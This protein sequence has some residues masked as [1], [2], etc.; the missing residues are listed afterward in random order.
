MS[1]RVGPGRLTLYAFLVLG[2]VFAVA[3]IAIVVVNSFNSSSFGAWPPPGF[4]T[5]WYTNLFDNGGFGGPAVRSIE[6]A[7]V[8]TAGSLLIGTLAALAFA[9]Y[10]L[11]GRRTLQGYLAAPLIVPKVAIGIAAFILFLKL[12]WYGSFGSL[13]LAHMLI[14]L[15]FVVT[16]ALAGLARVDR[17]VEEAAMDLGAAPWQVVWRATLPQMRGAL[18]A[19][20]AFSI[21]ISFD[22]LDASVFLV[23]LRSNTLPTAMYIYMQK[24]QD[25]TLAAL[26]T[27]LIGASLLAALLIAVLIGRIGGMRALS[28]AREGGTAV[29]LEDA[30]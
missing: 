20:A 16:L 4:S 30:V 28:A 12:G 17:T 3:P 25:P 21:I 8:A 9:R 14:T 27:I 6:L 22:E 24:F 7:A 5:R 10:R 11:T 18:L 1:V 23:G 13:V 29:A 2:V 19:A 26:S 15:P